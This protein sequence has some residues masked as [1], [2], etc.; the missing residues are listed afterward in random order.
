[1]R[2]DGAVPVVRVATC[3]FPVSADIDT[4][5]ARVKRQMTTAAQSNARVAHF[6]EAAL[7]GYAGVD[8]ESFDGMDWEHQQLYCR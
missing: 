4:N 6:P 2:E 3:Q 1:M 7:S 5:L 8:V